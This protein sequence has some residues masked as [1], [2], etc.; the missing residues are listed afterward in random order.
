MRNLESCEHVERFNELRFWER[1]LKL[2]KSKRATVGKI[3][4]REINK[5]RWAE[6]Y[7]SKDPREG[8]KKLIEED[9]GGNTRSRRVQ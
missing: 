4:R 1:I 5:N 2:Q 8:E 9:G 6:T 7:N 3:G